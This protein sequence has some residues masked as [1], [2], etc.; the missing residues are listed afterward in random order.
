MLVE[1]CKRASF[2]W[3]MRERKFVLVQDF[4]NLK[5]PRVRMELDFSNG[6]VGCT[7]ASTTK[8]PHLVAFCPPTD[9]ILAACVK[10]GNPRFDEV[11]EMLKREGY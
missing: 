2:H 5:P 9:P 10:A 1:A 7:F 11:A 3:F 8:P 6:T 4:S